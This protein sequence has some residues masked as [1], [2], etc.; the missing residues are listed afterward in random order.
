MLVQE[1]SSSSSSSRRSLG[2]G[3][4]GGGEEEE[5][6]KDGG[7]LFYVNRGGFPI[8]A[9][10]WDRMWS[11]V[12]AVHP[13]GQEMVDR[14]RNAAYLPK[15]SLLLVA[16]LGPVEPVLELNPQLRRFRWLLFSRQSVETRINDLN[17]AGC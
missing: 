6:E 2:G 4:G 10:T 16:P 15:V 1:E 11:H 8:E 17:P 7:V 3:G 14:I 12:A 13:D 5:E 9:P